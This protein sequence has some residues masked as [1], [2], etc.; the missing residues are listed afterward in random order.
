M[1]Q[2]LCV[3]LETAVCS[4]ITLP[5]TITIDAADG[6]DLELPHSRGSLM[7]RRLPT[8]EFCRVSERSIEEWNEELTKSRDSSILAMC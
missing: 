5:S 1:M 8:E 3:T 6:K 4:P 7:E 2:T